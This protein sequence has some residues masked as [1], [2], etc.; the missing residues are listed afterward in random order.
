MD[1]T[2]EQRLLLRGKGYISM[3]GGTHF[4]CRVVIPAGKMTAAQAQKLS[5]VCQ[6]FGKGYFTLTERG[7]VQIPWVGYEDLDKVTS[8]LAE[9]GLSIG[10]TGPRPRPARNCKGLACVASL[11][12]T[13]A[14]AEQI[15]ERFYKGHY[16][17]KLPSKFRINI[18]GCLN[19]CTKIR[20]A[21]L[22][23]QGRRPDQVAIFI[24]GM[25][26]HHCAVGREIAGLYSIP[27]ALNMIE[28]VLHFYKD[29]GLPGER[30]AKTIERIGF[31][32]VEKALLEN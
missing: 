22:G 16:D 30:F 24:G 15:N 28:K 17:I 31:E 10:G 9:V 5:D 12:D 21:C 32:A 7:N 19:N 18:S 1:I 25:D 14:V 4:S 26:G 13:E 6:M 8:T 29:N 23:L 27:E 2:N 11:Y 20:T 3:R